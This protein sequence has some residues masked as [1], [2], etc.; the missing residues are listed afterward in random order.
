MT[1]NI[2]IKR[3]FSFQHSSTGIGGEKCDQCDRGFVQSADVTMDHPTLNR[4]IPHGEMPECVACGE[5][6]SNWDR[7]LEDLQT[8]TQETV[9]KARRVKVNFY[10]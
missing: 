9:G 10:D 8:K 3:F 5:C 6:F 1:I 4:T 7:I 2:I